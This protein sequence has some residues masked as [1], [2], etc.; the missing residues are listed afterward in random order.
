[1]PTSPSMNVILLLHDV[2]FVNAG[3]CESRP[4]SSGPVWIARRSR[5]LIAPSAAFRAWSW[6]GRL[7]VIFRLG[8]EMVGDSTVAG[9]GKPPSVGGGAKPP[10][11]REGRSARL[12]EDDSEGF[13]GCADAG[14]VRRALAAAIATSG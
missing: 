6:R 2:V 1:M 4:K 12:G 7:S 8:A 13:V 3:S 14:A 10:E 5:A 9:G 11:F